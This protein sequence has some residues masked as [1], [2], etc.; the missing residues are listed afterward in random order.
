MSVSDATQWEP[1]GAPACVNAPMGLDLQKLL[2]E[3]LVVDFDT[4]I[5]FGI[6][7][8]LTRPGRRRAVARVFES[9]PMFILTHVSFLTRYPGPELYTRTPLTR[10]PGAGEG[11]EAVRGSAA[12]R[13]SSAPRAGPPPGSPGWPGP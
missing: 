3:A 1:L 2:K 6:D 13:D 9:S 10:T 5:P 8:T 11:A 12:S 7:D 4:Q